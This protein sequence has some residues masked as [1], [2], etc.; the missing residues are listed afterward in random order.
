MGMQNISY[1][2]TFLKILLIT[3]L[4]KYLEKSKYVYGRILQILYDRGNLI[5]VPEYRR[6]MIVDSQVQNPRE[7]ISKIIARRKWHY[8]YDPNVLNLIITIYQDQEGSL[9]QEIIARFRA[10]VLQF[11]TL[12]TLHRF[13]P[14]PFLAF[15]FRLRDDY[16]RNLIIPGVDL[17]L[18]LLFPKRVALIAFFSEF[19]YYL[20]NGLS[21]HLIHQV[22]EYMPRLITLLSHQNKY[23]LYLGLSGPVIYGM[24]QLNPLTLGVLPLIAKYNFIYLYL[25][26]FGYF[27]NY[28]PYHLMTLMS[29]LYL[30]INLTD[31]QNT[32]IKNTNINLIKSYWSTDQLKES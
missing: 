16:P 29:L 31:Y 32:P 11:F 9:L 18:V 19:C 8:F 20:N 28:D 27:S 2:W 3:T 1:I 7:T 14:I 4:I 17:G 26:T 30:K 25:L 6:S 24:N 13:I 21:H 10:R 23:N 12:W 22:K 5:E 15:L